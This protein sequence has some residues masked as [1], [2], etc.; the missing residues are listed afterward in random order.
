MEK[1]AA[2]FL[3]VVTM[4]SQFFGLA[5]S[6]SYQKYVHLKD[7]LHL[8]AHKS[9]VVSQYNEGKHDGKIWNE[10]DVFSLD[11]TVIL[12]KEK[13]RDFR[14]LN[15]TDLHFEDFGYRS[16]F[17]V[18]GETTIRRMVAE[19]SPD[20]I[21]VSGDIV[22]GESDSY[23]IKRIT[24]LF[25]SFGVP[26]A[27]VFGNHD[28]EANCDL[29]YLCDIMM[30]GPHCLMKKSDPEM[31]YGNYIINIAEDGENGEPVIIETLFMMDSHHDMPND[32]QVRWYTWASEAITEL[33]G[34][35][36]EFTAIMHIP[37]P[38]YQIAYDLSWDADNKKWIDGKNAY[39]SL[40]ESIC[41][42]KD[43]DGH[44][45]PSPFFEA[46]KNSGG[47]YIF[48]G[49]EH[50]NNFSVEY[51]GVRLTYTMKLGYGSGFQVGF[52]GGTVISVGSSGINRI[53]HYTVSFGVKIPLVDIDCTKDKK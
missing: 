47:R 30:S 11:D 12:K 49:H 23:S 41:C 42:V 28:D 35:R 7:T 25:E 34:G 20:L 26:W 19:T 8:I 3:S 5:G 51:E 14:I 31:G 17:S 46:F 53:T 10:N 6:D 29:D 32:K 1:I 45:S 24:D 15:L 4:F 38:E 2:F 39:G 27:P 43:A 37:L 36:S 40:H 13:D 52:N 9:E 22:C 16:V 48:C 18:E 33:T 21:T 44:A 50:M